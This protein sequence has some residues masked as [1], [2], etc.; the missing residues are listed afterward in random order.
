MYARG[1]VCVHQL[2]YNFLNS[3]D[4]SLRSIE[5]VS[6]RN[7][8]TT[9]MDDDDWDENFLDSLTEEESI[10]VRWYVTVLEV[11]EFNVA[12][13]ACFQKLIQSFKEAV[14][15]VEDIKIFLED[16]GSVE[17]ADSATFLLAQM[18]RSYCS[19]KLKQSTLD[20]YFEQAQ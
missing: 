19:T 10:I 18:A 8:Q 17:L 2:L 4:V 3:F 13:P 14:E 1:V 9:S 5:S 15:S 6:A 7:F 20:Q 12:P 11:E 16:R